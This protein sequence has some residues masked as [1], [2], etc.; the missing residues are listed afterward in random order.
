MESKSPNSRSPA[1]TRKSHT[2]LRRAL[3]A[4]QQTKRNVTAPTFPR[5][6]GLVHLHSSKLVF[7]RPQLTV[8]LLIAVITML[9]LLNCL[10]PHDLHFLHGSLVFH[11]HVVHLLHLG[12]EKQQPSQPASQ[13]MGSRGFCKEVPGVL[14]H[15]LWLPHLCTMQAM[16]TTTPS[17]HCCNLIQVAGHSNKQEHHLPASLRAASLS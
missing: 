7:P 4:E 6:S 12:E 14:Q 3:S 17:R 15:S 8:H 13:C 2:P 9:V 1:L 11:D 5:T 10:L 16:I